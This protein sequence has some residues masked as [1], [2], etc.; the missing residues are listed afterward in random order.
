MNKIFVYGTLMPGQCRY[1]LISEH[2]VDI[3][4]VT[5]K[6]HALFLYN[7]MDQSYPFMVPLSG[8]E[9]K[10]VVL[11]FNESNS[12]E[13]LE[14]IDE[15]ET[16]AGYVRSECVVNENDGTNHS[17]ITY[18]P[19]NP[20]VIE[21]I[22]N[23]LPKIETGDWAAFY[24][25]FLIVKLN[26]LMSESQE[27]FLVDLK[28]G[29]VVSYDVENDRLKKTAERKTTIECKME[30]EIGISEMSK[31]LIP[32][33]TLSTHITRKGGVLILLFNIGEI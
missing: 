4:E 14:F 26:K 28:N 18:I 15:M 7:D 32:L 6:D 20:D 19:T 23:D 30:D 2:V 8:G 10:G 5:L 29:G 17:V 25:L 22:I 1:F 11:T 12:E 3:K 27:I 33:L 13:I 21:W 16:P 24:P 31:I 9:V